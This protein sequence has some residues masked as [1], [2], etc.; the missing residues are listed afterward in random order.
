[1]LKNKLKKLIFNI[2]NQK[3][4]ED[5]KSKTEILQQFEKERKALN[6]S[7]KIFDKLLFKLKEETIAKIATNN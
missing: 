7:R 4:T 3:M 2:D 1:M 6:A 5:K